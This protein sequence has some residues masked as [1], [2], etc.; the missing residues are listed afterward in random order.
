[1]GDRRE[2]CHI[3][4]RESLGAA[5]AYRVWGERFAPITPSS[6]TPTVSREFT[7]I[8]KLL[9]SSASP[10]PAR[11]GPWDAPVQG[12]LSRSKEVLLLTLKDGGPGNPEAASPEESRPRDQ[13]DD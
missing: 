8:E 10:S 9:A 1:M 2:M 11:S 12:T 13:A 5:E 7:N 3:I 4:P 6:P